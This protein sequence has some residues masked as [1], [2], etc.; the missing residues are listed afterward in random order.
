MS[1]KHGRGSQGSILERV[2]SIKVEWGTGSFQR[3]TLHVTDI[4]AVL[5]QATG[6]FRVP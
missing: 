6:N 4:N 5:A 1:P 3:P 2:E